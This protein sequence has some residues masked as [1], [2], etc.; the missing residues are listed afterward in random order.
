G[1]DRVRAVTGELAPAGEVV[2]LDVVL[3][4]PRPV[5][6]VQA[7]PAPGS[8][9]AV[10]P[11][12]GAVLGEAQG[13]PVTGADDLV[14]GQAQTGELTELG[15]GGG[16]VGFVAPGQVVDAHVQRVARHHDVVADAQVVPGG[17]VDAVPAHQ[18][19]KRLRDE[20]LHRSASLEPRLAALGE[21]ADA[22]GRVAGRVQHG[23]RL[24][25][26]AGLAAVHAPV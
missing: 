13:Q 20:G 19:Y 10:V 16:L 18:C 21:G 2:L 9:G 4:Q 3:Q 8:A 11:G 24:D 12:R 26:V 25:A 22:L 15:G 23:D 17:V 7:D 6:P 5:P 1:L 14:D